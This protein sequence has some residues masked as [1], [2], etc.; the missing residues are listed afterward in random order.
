[1][2]KRGLDS[3][4]SKRPPV[5]SRFAIVKCMACK[6]RTKIAMDDWQ[7]YKRRRDVLMF[8]CQRSNCNGFTARVMS[9]SRT[10]FDLHDDPWNDLL[11]TANKV[12]KFDETDKALAGDWSTCSIGC[13]LDVSGDPVFYGD[14]EISREDMV[15]AYGNRSAGLGDKFFT[16]VDEDNVGLAKRVDE[17]IKLYVQQCMARRIDLFGRFAAFQNG[18]V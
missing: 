8:D 17:K 5:E 12:E 18:I 15:W 14:D 4:V 9:V 3:F 1:M 10:F 11:E 6:I 13:K 7:K 2:W 16:A